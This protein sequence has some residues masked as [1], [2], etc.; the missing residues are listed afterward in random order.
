MNGKQVAVLVVLVVFSLLSAVPLYHYGYVGIFEF[1]LANSA[2]LQVL[3]DL[4]I[5]LSLVV[6]WMWE[7]ANERGIS[8]WPYLLITLFAGSFGPLLY[9][10]RRLG[11]PAP[12][13]SRDAGA[14]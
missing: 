6:I 8:V 3:A 11:H 10:L 5:A 7:D 14:A 2:T 4:I 9:L 13:V 12:V 1:V